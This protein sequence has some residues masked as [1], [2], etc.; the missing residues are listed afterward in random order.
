ME[1]KE[2]RA[3]EEKVRDIYHD[4]RYELKF[5]QEGQEIDSDKLKEIH[6]EII[7]GFKSGQK[8]I[9]TELKSLQILA[10]E[11]QVLLKTARRE[12]NKNRTDELILNS[13]NIEYQDSIYRNLADTIAWQMLNGE[14]YLYRRFYTG[15]TGAKDL[16]DKAFSHVVDFSDRVNEDPDAFC[17]IADITNN[18]QLGDCLIRDNDGIK[19]SEI[20]SGEMNFKAIDIINDRKL[21]DDDF[22][23]K[24]LS[25][26][27][28]DKFI[29]QMKRMVS[30]KGKTERAAKIV[31]ENSGPDPKYKDTNIHIVENNFQ[32]DT[33]HMELLGLLS[34]LKSQDWAY[35]CVGAIVHIGVYKNDWR[36]YG[37]FAMEQLCD[38]FPFID[39]MSSRGVMICEP[40]FLKP[41]P[42]DVIMDIVFGRIKVFIGIDYNNFIK[43]SNDLGVDASWSTAKELQKYLQKFTYNKREIFSIDNKGI[44]LEIDGNE[45]FVGHGF[46]SK[47][48]FDHFLPETMILKYVGMISDIVNRKKQD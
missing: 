6:R 17:L 35:T 11:N 46:F 34:Q 12:G 45:I 36:V 39:L 9:L 3:F 21:T 26:E 20:K 32:I 44:K 27:F 31:K 29:K 42:E 41:F 24:K 18:I 30:Q 7:A 40:I 47:I 4:V 37:Q 33:Y 48:L 5:K 14:H 28:E 2:D 10:K 22:N 43:F 23:E 25:E 15:E 8:K 38:P 16:S 13:K 1:L 19:V